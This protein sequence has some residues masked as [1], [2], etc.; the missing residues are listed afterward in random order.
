VDGYKR[1]GSSGLFVPAK[2]AKQIGIGCPKCD[3][4]F[5]QDPTLSQASPRAQEFIHRHM[6]CGQ[7]DALEMRGGELVIT[8]PV[9]L[10]IQKS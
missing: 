9:Q 1:D 3:D 4:H 2:L 5:L 8:G 10:V 7:L 6:K